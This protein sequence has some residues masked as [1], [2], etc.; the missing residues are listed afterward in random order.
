MR[1]GFLEGII[2]I[3]TCEAALGEVETDQVYTALFGLN[4]Y[5]KR[6]NNGNDFFRKSCGLFDA[7]VGDEDNL[8]LQ[9]VEAPHN[10]K[11]ILGKIPTTDLITWTGL[12]R[13][14]VR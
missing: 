7:G 6:Y 1:Y 4:E 12:S 5:L 13:I 11:K 10:W 14:D 2:N 9:F 8:I 3:E